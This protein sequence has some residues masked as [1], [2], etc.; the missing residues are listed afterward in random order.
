MTEPVEQTARIESID[1]LRGFALLG[2]LLLNILAFGLHS[3][4]YFNPLISIGETE[5]AGE[6][7][8][9]LARLGGEAVVGALDLLPAG[10]A[11]F[12]PQNEAAVTMT[13]RLRKEDG[14]VDFGSL[15]SSG[16]VRHV[17]AMTPW[18]GARTAL[19]RPVGEATPLTIHEAIAQDPSTWEG[20]RPGDLM[21]DGGRLFVALGEGCAELT[22]VQ[23]AGK[24]PMDVGEFL[25]GARLEADARLESE[26]CPE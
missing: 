4:G 21:A 13:R 16:L 15:D 7:H 20:A 22:R 23:P 17:R 12:S 24:R 6:V 10:T 11:E 18:P 25:R 5:T 8:D 2:I 3:A 26:P 1:V 9:R 19:V 14:R